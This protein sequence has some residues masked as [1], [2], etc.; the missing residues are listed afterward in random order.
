VDADGPDD[1]PG[2]LDDDLRLHTTFRYPSPVI[3]QGD[4]G[5][6]PT[7]GDD[8]DGDGDLGERLPLDLSGRS[9]LIGFTTITPTVD[10]GAY[11]ANILDV[12]AEGD[13]LLGGGMAFRLEHLQLLSAD[14][15]AQALQNYANFN[16]G[17]W[18][19]AFCSDYGNINDHGYCPETGPDHVRNDLL[20]AVDLY[21]VAVGWPTS[22]FTTH[23]GLELP[24]R[25]LGG[26]GVMS[27]TKEIA[28]DHLI[29]GNEFLVDATDYRFSTAGIP[30][31]DE[32]IGR[33]L[34]ELAQARRQFELILDLVF[35]AFNDWGVGDY[36]GGDQFETFGVASS[37]MMTTLDETA[38]RYYM[39][40]RSSDA[41][42]VYERAERNQSLHLMA[43][44]DLAQTMGNDY[45]IN[46]SYEMLNNLSRMRDRATAIHDGL[47]FFG[48]AP[49]YAPLQPYDQLL[50]LVEGPTGN[51][52]LLGTARDL[53]DQAREAQRT[54]DANASDMS[55]ELD[56]LTVEL[57]DQLFELCGK[58]EDEDGDGFG[59][60]DVCEGGLM[61]QNQA[62]FEAAY[63]RQALAWMRAQNIAREIEIEQERAGEVIQVNLGT[64]QDIA[65]ADLAIGK[66][67]AYRQTQ[68][69]ASSSEAS[70]HL[71]V[72]IS[73]EAWAEAGGKTSSSPTNNETYAAAAV[74]GIVRNFFTYGREWTW[75]DATETT[76]DPN[77]AVIGT[78]ESIKSL[79]QAEAQAE[80]EGAN[81]A[82]TIKNL[83]LR[84][85]EALR[86]YEIATKELNEVAAEHNHM[87]ERRSRLLNKRAQAINRVV[88]HNSHLL[89]PAYRIWRDSLTT[90][91]AEAH[92]LAAQFAYLTAQASEYELLT[93][94][95]AI[96]D[97]FKA[98][99]ANDIRLFLDD[100]KVWHQALD[101]PGQLNRYPYT[102]SVA[103]DVF[104]LTDEQLDPDGDLSEGELDQKRHAA[105][106]DE[107]RS[108]IFDG[109]LEIVFSTS[110]DQQRPG[111]EYVFSPHIWN[112]RIA[113]KGA[114]LADNVGVKVNI[115]TSETVEAGNVEVVLTH[116]GQASYRNA[117]GEEVIYDP[118]TAAPVGYLAPE[119]LSPA[120]TTIV[121]RPEIN[122]Q[123]GLANGGLV[124]LSV[125]AS[126]WKLR[127][128]EE[129]WGDLD[130]TQIEDIEIYLD[131]TGR[132]LPS[133]ETAA[134]QDAARLKA[135][136]AMEPPADERLRQL[137]AVGESE[138][139]GDGSSILGIESRTL[140]PATP[141]EISGS[142]YG[143]IVIT[144]PITLGVQLLNFDLVNLD[145][146]LSGT[147]N[148][149]ET[150][151]Y[152]GAIGLHGVASGDAFTLASD[153][154][155]T[156][157]AGRT[158]TQ[159]F[160]LVGHAEEE[161]EV[162]RASYTGL[163]TNLLPEPIVVQGAF[164]GSR[165]GAPAGNGLLVETAARSV[166]LGGSTV[167]T[168]TLIDNLMQPITQTGGVTYSI[169]FTSDLGAVSP[170]SV[171]VVDGVALAT[172]TAGA[173]QG[174]AIIRA[175]TGEMTGTVR[176][177]I[178]QSRLYLP[179]VVRNYPHAGQGPDLVVDTM[180]VT[181][182]GVEMV[183]RNQ[184]DV[185]VLPEDQFWVD[186]YVAPDPAPTRVNQPW[187]S[188][189]GEGLVWG[190]PAEALPLG[191]DEVMSLAY[192]TDP[193]A[194]NLY[195]YAK[196]SNFPGSLAEGTLVYVQV[197]SW[198]PDT[199]YGAV[200]EN[201][202][203]VGGGYNN[204][205]GPMFS[206][207]EGMVQKPRQTAI[208]GPEVSPPGPLDGLSPRPSDFNSKK[209]QGVIPLRGPR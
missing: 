81:S 147:V 174:E 107:L 193:A 171:E 17:E 7:D 9:R 69:Q 106:Q 13:A 100:L 12:L 71:G 162:L 32:I 130:Y 78:W 111:G 37:L 127:I 134:Q 1:V 121:L 170:R 2:T 75:L 133:W 202:E 169:T 70:L 204:I 90:Q 113:G 86:E 85:S 159:S 61:A 191:P 53:E 66:L 48:F 59:D 117:S 3:D 146:A 160:Q 96:D 42:A 80:I 22:I 74:K 144:S 50:E 30:Y 129:S 196:L 44:A 92:G 27:A 83:L 139:N 179:L 97:I 182:D 51:T 35:R 6:L 95:P 45:L 173:E 175:T 93:P 136:L 181:A 110:L 34:D 122:G 199:S 14:T 68:T 205:L 151:L 172:F 138:T 56:N 184:G 183:I 77:A 31:A 128:P 89:S 157:V 140:A 99:T 167:V 98:R 65:A 137:A 104:S 105:F 188:L 143:N 55:T 155:V 26:G 145:G 200:L 108:W 118:A 124:N 132:A 63:I 208:P 156:L 28:N 58:S 25:A 36:C 47:D 163:I 64:G 4:N 79:Q 109:D 76:W 135:G 161:A 177:E 52:G 20:D 46:G 40:G 186:L 87:I 91:S 125:A 84:Q 206:R 197:D 166:P 49:E 54:F 198:N 67:Q 21:R 43:L 195:Y 123:G 131:T 115:V 29:F 41:L 16:D 60:Y 103:E 102:L 5:A 189:C 149:A 154:Y 194:P 120:D 201:H 33:E 168:A 178:G 19:Y 88:S 82:A 8:L 112:N 62:A 209:R 185:P 148:V 11:E 187:D 165:P 39:L 176:V 180:S 150:A 190:I 192:S 18:Y 116:D 72:D 152:S 101:L 24:V 142:Y 94:Y 153:T 141:G 57:S 10:M 207:T 38:S 23:D 114:P 73:V 158:V 119:E 126:H 203:A 15:Q 164:I